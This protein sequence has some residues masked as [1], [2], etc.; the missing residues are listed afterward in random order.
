MGPNI[1]QTPG[2]MLYSVQ[3]PVEAQHSY[4]DQF[5]LQQHQ[6]QAEYQQQL[7]DE[8]RQLQEEGHKQELK[9][10]KLE[11]PNSKKA[12]EELKK[13][14]EKEI[15]IIPQDSPKIQSTRDQRRRLSRTGNTRDVNNPVI[16]K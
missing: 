8:E 3:S 1:N 2:P 4:D 13:Q 15:K 16:K 12:K 14:Q 11:E 7:L 6:Q 9:K 5:L 10:Q